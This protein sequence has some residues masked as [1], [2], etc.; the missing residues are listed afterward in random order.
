MCKSFIMLTIILKNISLIFG[1]AVRFQFV[2]LTNEKGHEI[3][4]NHE[5]ISFHVPLTETTVKT[6]RIIQM[7]IENGLDPNLS[8]PK[9]RSL[10][11]KISL[12]FKRVVR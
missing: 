9:K 6:Y 10:L 4:L 11:S 8:A 1:A 12:I 3:N 2:S 5:T 7:C